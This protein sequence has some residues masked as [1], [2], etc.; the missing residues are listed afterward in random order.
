MN[1]QMFRKG[2]PLIIFNGFELLIV[3]IRMSILTRLLGAYEF[4]F[5]SA[6]SATYAAVEQITDMAIYRFVISSPRA[7]YAAAVAAAHAVALLRGLAVAVCLLAISRPVACTMAGCSDWLSFAMLAP[8]TLIRSFENLEMR[9][10]ERDYNYSRQLIASLASH[11]AGLAAL[12]AT[13]LPWQ[14]HLA[15]VAYLTAQSLVYVLASHILAR[16]AFRADFNSTFF[17]HAARF[18]A[19]LIINGF[20]AA[21]TSQGDRLLVGALFGLPVLA[22]YAVI[23]LVAIVPISVLFKIIGPLQLAGLTNASHD[24]TAYGARKQLFGRGVPIIA[25]L[26]ALSLMALLQTMLPLLFGP[27]Y[28][29]SAVVAV[30]IGLI[31]FVR[32]VRIEP[33]TSLLLHARQ[34]GGLA[35]AS[36]AVAVGL[37]AAAILGSIHK[38]IEF[39]LAGGLI[40]EIAAWCAM[41]ATTRRLLGAA[42]RDY[43]F[44]V[45]GVVVVVSA[46]GALVMLSRPGE[47]LAG[48]LAICGSTAALLIG[49]ALLALPNPHRRGYRSSLFPAAVGMHPANTT[50]E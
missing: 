31:A 45:T 50:A 34:T 6:L 36:Q 3:F 13:A 26:Y 9:V 12:L 5:A 30:L 40:G 17:R 29:N 24:H 1:L 10:S 11:T 16:T 35:L 14:N 39:V 2:A 8:I 48:R 44:S 41:T 27:R 20:A 7:D 4:G 49:V 32:I 46:A 21:I 42:S 25:G 33:H 22:L 47:V 28:Q 19:P 37:V 43:L 18:G 23:I 15:L 38:S